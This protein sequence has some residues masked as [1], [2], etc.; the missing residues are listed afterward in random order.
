[1]ENRL[2]VQT[3]F[4]RAIVHSKALSKESEDLLVV[5]MLS[6]MKEIFKVEGTMS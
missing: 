6:N 5:F 1:M 4:S 3:S 2:A